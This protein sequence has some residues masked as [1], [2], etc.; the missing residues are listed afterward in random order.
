[1]TASFAPIWAVDVIGSILMIVL[2][3]LCFRLARRLKQ[4]EPDNVMWTYLVW[5][6]SALKPAATR[7][8]NACSP[9]WPTST[10]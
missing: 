10:V 3:I 8:R 1:M 5:I 4:R 2:S 7:R 6:C 9:H